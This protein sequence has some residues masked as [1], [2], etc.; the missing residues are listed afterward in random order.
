VFIFAQTGIFP[1]KRPFY[2]NKMAISLSKHYSVGE[3][4]NIYPKIS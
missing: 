3:K 4:S 2:Y 1:S